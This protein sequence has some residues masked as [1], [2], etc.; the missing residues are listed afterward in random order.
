LMGSK[1][2]NAEQAAV[3]NADV[4]MLVADLTGKLITLPYANPQN[5]LSGSTVAIVNTTR[6][7]VIAAQGGSVRTYLT[8]ILVTNGHTTVG[9][10]VNIED[11]TTVK[12]SGFAGPLGGF[13]VT[14]PVPLVGTANTAWNVSATTTGGSVIC[15]LSGYKGI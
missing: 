13:S 11:N 14:L 12:Y 7:E 1:A 6:T 5:F 3:G 15:S 4:V 8:N 9:T 2:I 10:I